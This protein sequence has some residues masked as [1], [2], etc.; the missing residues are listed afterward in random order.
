MNLYSY[1]VHQINLLA[2]SVFSVNQIG[3][4]DTKLNCNGFLIKPLTVDIKPAELKFIS[5]LI[6]TKD[7]THAL[8]LI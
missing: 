6:V 8:L 2:D 1:F 7:V 5:Y 3:I 4:K